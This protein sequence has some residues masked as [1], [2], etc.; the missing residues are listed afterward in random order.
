MADASALLP[1]GE[2]RKNFPLWP[3]RHTNWNVVLNWVLSLVQGCG[4]SI[5]NGTVLAAFI[6][7]LCGTS[8][9]GKAKGNSYVGYVE[10]A[11]GVIMLVV[12]LPIGWLADKTSKSAIV[13]FGGALVPVA[14]GATIYAAIYG[15]AETSHFF[16][17]Y[18][19]LF[20]AMCMWGIAYAIFQGP[21]Q[22]LLAD[23][24]PTGNRSWYFTKNAQLNFLANA[25][26]PIVAIAMFALHGDEWHPTTLRNVLIVGIG[27]N[28]LM[29]IPMM[30]M[31]DDCALAEEMAGAAPG[32]APSAAPTSDTPESGGGYASAEAQANVHAQRSARLRRVPYVVFSSGIL[33]A[34]GSGMTIKFF[35]LFFKNDLRLS[36]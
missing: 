6:Y 2:E 26:G 25:A 19:I 7:E 22:A 16:T 20:G 10:A 29:T 5:W 35:P 32:T 12:S 8:R 4:D 30:L 36:P 24:T 27:I 14:S 11:Q 3:F 33:F 13:R 15:A 9:A 28:V 23:S 17:S 18:W 34:L 31:R 1:P 21:A